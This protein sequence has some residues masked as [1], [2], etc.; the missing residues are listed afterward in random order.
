M[1]KGEIVRYE[2]FLL[3]PQCFQKDLYCRHVEDQ[4]LFLERINKSGHVNDVLEERER[5]IIDIPVAGKVPPDE[6]VA[7]VTDIIYL[8]LLTCMY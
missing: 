3:L 8:C 5:Y 7:T 2:Q 1:G 4:G 6:T